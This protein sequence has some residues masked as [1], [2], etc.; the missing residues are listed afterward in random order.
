MMDKNIYTDITASLVKYIFPRL[1]MGTVSLQTI[2]HTLENPPTC[3]I[4]SSMD[5]ATFSES[6]RSE[7]FWHTLAYPLR[8]AEITHP[9]THPHTPLLLHVGN[10]NWNL[11]IGRKFIKIPI[12]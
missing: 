10:P 12:R 11:K 1:Y 4:F 9:L 8:V 7:P 2:V 3:D 5:I 6:S